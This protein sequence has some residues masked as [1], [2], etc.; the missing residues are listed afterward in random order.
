[1]I[2]SNPP[3]IFLYG[4]INF[5]VVMKDINTVIDSNFYTLKTMHNNITRMNVHNPDRCRKL[6][7]HFK[8]IGIVYH[9]YKT[10]EERSFRI[11]INNIH[12]TYDTEPIKLHLIS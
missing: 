4:V 10:K 1:M 5:Q 7:T 6:I 11:V 2:T 9:S 3:P 8:N 12:H